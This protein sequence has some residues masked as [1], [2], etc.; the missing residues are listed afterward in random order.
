MLR[1]VLPALML[2]GAAQ[3]GEA[4]GGYMFIVGA[5]PSDIPAETEVDFM[6]KP[7]RERVGA[8]S[9]AWSAECGADVFAWHSNLI[10]NEDGPFT[11]DMWIGILAMEPTK[12]ALLAALPDSACVAGGYIAQGIVVYPS[13]YQYCAFNEGTPDYD[14]ENCD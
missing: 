11:P 5:I 2:T 8:L 9:A 1:Y 4:V 7:F 10:S 13:A 14:A 12:E 6:R 3:A